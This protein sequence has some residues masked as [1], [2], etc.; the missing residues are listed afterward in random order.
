MLERAAICAAISGARIAGNVALAAAKAEQGQ[1]LGNAPK[2]RRRATSIARSSRSS[3]TTPWQEILRGSFAPASWQA[4]PHLGS[5][6]GCWRL[7]SSPPY[8]A[9]VA[10]A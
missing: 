6:S 7:A 3:G 2:A 8:L 9:M 5:P 4:K 1:P 10:L